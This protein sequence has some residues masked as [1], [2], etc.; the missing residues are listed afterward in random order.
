[1][2]L[3]RK[4]RIWWEPVSEATSYVVYASR[5]SE[6]M[7]PTKFSWG[8]SPNMISK[9]AIG[10]TE[11]VIPDEWPEFPVEPGTYHIAITSKDDVG[12][13]S[14]PFLLSGWFKFIAP[15]APSRGGIE[16]L[17]LGHPEPGNAAP[18]FTREGRTIIEKGLEEVKNNKDVWDAYLGRE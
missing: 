14:D 2:P 5:D 11:L 4:R 7:D 12:N 8:N 15:L 10:K 18:S 9:P 16:I 1:M 6:V 3:V 17:S 13:Q